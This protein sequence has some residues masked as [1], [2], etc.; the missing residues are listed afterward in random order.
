MAMATAANRR[1]VTGKWVKVRGRV[2]DQFG[3]P[4]EGLEV[5]GGLTYPSCDG[6]QGRPQKTCERPTDGDGCYELPFQLD[7][8]GGTVYVM[9]PRRH[10]EPDES[11]LVLKR[12]YRVDL[13][14]CEGEITI[15]E[16]RYESGACMLSGG[17]E[18]EVVGCDGRRPEYEPFDGVTVQICDPKGEV[19]GTKS[20]DI[21]GR[22]SLPMP[23][24]GPLYLQFPQVQTV[25]GQCWRLEEPEREVLAPCDRPF[26]LSDP[27]RY[28]LS[29]ARIIGVIT[30]GKCGL[31]GF[32]VK[33]IHSRAEPI[34]SRAKP[35][36]SPAEPSVEAT[37]DADGCYRFD[38]VAPGSVRLIFRETFCDGEQKEWELNPA[39]EAVQCLDEVKAGDLIHATPVTYGPEV[40]AI[41]CHVTL[42]DGTAAANRVVRV[43]DE[44]DK[45]V[46]LGMTDANGDACIDVGR[47][48]RYKVTVYPDAA[49]ADVPYSQT[50]SV[51]S[52]THVRF[53]VPNLQ[54][55]GEQVAAAFQAATQSGIAAFQAAAQSGI[56][57]AQAAV[58]GFADAA[59]SRV[60]AVGEALID[61]STYPV[62]TEPVSFPYPTGG[63]AGGGTSGGAGAAARARRWG[64]WSRGRSARCSA[65]G[66]SRAIPRDSS[67]P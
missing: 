16:R 35:I 5:Q 53:Q 63:G 47:R 64:R 42:P 11:V 37:T 36:H 33:L 61:T 57:A 9:F 21:F 45:E 8:P 28:V 34:H 51:N 48:G 26:V 3:Q 46:K 52:P 41:Y 55:A 29:L 15:P 25:D 19:I 20:T 12:G 27:V 13:E 2:V 62:L 49:A 65:G 7:G 31:A 10:Q 60:S 23:K 1:K 50:V 66:P 22:F 40:H 14:A 54:S 39:S 67:R 43:Y 4:I 17:V 18:R 44:N 24:E 59:G 30:D 56:D 38:K 58:T 32:P 6:A